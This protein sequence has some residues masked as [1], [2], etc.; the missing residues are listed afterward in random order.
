MMLA[1]EISH[2]LK[3]HKGKRGLM[4]MKLDMKKAYDRL[5]WGVLVKVMRAM[6]FNEKFQRLIHSCVNSVTFSLLLNGNIMRNF[7]P[8]RGL[9]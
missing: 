7:K 6:R 3:K 2:N 9:Q 8:D 4:I 5:E 1:Q